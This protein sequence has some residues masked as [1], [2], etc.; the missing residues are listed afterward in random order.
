MSLVLD[1]EIDEYNREK[2]IDYDDCSIME[3]DL[4]EFEPEDLED[5]NYYDILS[6]PRDISFKS[7]KIQFDRLIDKYNPD[8]KGEHAIHVYKKI[9][10]AY[11]T[12]MN[13]YER[14]RYDVL[15]DQAD[16]ISHMDEDINDNKVSDNTNR[17]V[18]F[19]NG[20]T[21]NPAV[22]QILGGLEKM[23]NNNPFFKNTGLNFDLASSRTNINKN[24]NPNMNPNIN[25]NINSNMNPNMNPNRVI[26]G[27]S[28][29]NPFQ[30]KNPFGFFSRGSTTFDMVS[31]TMQY[32]NPFA[33]NRNLYGA[34]NIPMNF[35]SK[36]NTMDKFNLRSDQTTNPYE[37]SKLEIP[38]INIADTVLDKKSDGLGLKSKV[39][40]AKKVPQKRTRR[41]TNIKPKVE[42][43][44]MIQ[45]KKRTRRVTKRKPTGRGRG[46]P[47]KTNTTPK[48]RVRRTK[49][50]VADNKA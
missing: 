34:P 35:S 45:S 28:R 48:K 47:K 9:I 38:T 16:D 29:Q 39:K 50:K 46:R 20:D 5:M 7:L 31:N 32:S 42:E 11:K 25:S 33:Q 4:S 12:L 40:K 3:Y 10:E 14:G 30:N 27:Q 36:Y 15:I 18:N 43:E 1:K 21:N 22:Q 2:F 6:V 26:N 41:V 44:D 17:T 8:K 13:P 24:M 23:F 37:K 49:K 19:T